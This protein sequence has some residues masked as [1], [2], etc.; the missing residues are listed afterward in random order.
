MT[1]LETHQTIQIEI[2][3]DIVC[4]FCYIGKRNLEIALAKF[5]ERERVRLHWMSFELDPEGK[6]KPEGNVYE[7]LARKYGR[8]LDWAKQASAQ[9]AMRAK[10]V[11]LQFDYDRVIPANTFNAHRL[12]HLAD[13]RGVQDKAEERLMSAYFSEGQNIN[14]LATLQKLAVEI[15]LDPV[16]AK[17]TLNSDAYTDDVR[18]DEQAA[19]NIGITGVP[20]FLFN[21]EVPVSGAQPPEVFLS[22]L[23]EILNVEK[24]G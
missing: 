11:G 4:P 13:H 24:H 22:T 10:E 19:M 21:R 14:D 8:S 9:T 18:R 1:T 6:K 2:W 7:L 16:E 23:R 12:V 20:F 17:N 15:G 5:P 3:S